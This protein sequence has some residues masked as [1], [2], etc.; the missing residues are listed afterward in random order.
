MKSILG[1]LESHPNLF[2]G[3]HKLQE[4]KKVSQMLAASW[5]D[6]V[7]CDPE[8]PIHQRTEEDKSS[9]MPILAMKVVG[10]ERWR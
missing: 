10:L 4:E 7:V 2:L 8:H 1:N 5:N 6:D 3:G 9:S